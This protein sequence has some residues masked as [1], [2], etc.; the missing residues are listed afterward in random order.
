MQILEL[1]SNITLR[2]F[3]RPFEAVLSFKSL[4][5][6]VLDHRLSSYFTWLALFTPRFSW[7]YFWGQNGEKK[8]GHWRPMEAAWGHLR[9]FEAK[10][11][12]WVSKFIFFHADS[13]NGL[14]HNFEAVFEAN[15]RL[16]CYLKAY[17]KGF[18]TTDWAQILRGWLFLRLG[19]HEH[20]FEAKSEK[21]MRSL[22]AN[23]GIFFHADS[24]NDL[25]HNF[26][27][28]LSFKSLFEKVPEG[29]QGSDFVWRAKIKKI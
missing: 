17:L 5:E 18:H 20:V 27:A 16:F 22:E 21:K 10:V 3:L 28:V 8:W 7:A 12:L 4:F 15:L 23:G 26:E 13:G 2:L 6:G 11:K 14:K 29:L 25:K 9:P 24:G 1:A 19:F